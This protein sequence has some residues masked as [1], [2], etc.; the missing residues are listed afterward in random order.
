M[1]QEW[2]PL[3]APYTDEHASHWIGRTAPEALASGRGLVRAIDVGGRFAGTIDFKRTEWVA[4]VTEIGYMASPWARSQ[5]FV[6]EAVRVMSEWAL[7]DL[8]LERVELRIATG[9]AASLR[10]AEK[11][12]FQ[13]AGLARSAGYVHA[14][15]VDLAIFSLVRSDLDS[16]A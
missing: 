4:G 3:P 2:L 5:G 9:N 10:V 15:R 7:T 12:R 1:T 14:G 8:G 6:T 11:S 13:R 16:I